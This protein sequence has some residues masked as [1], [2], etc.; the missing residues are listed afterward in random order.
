MSGFFFDVDSNEFGIVSKFLTSAKRLLNEYST[1]CCML[2]T[3]LFR[4]TLVCHPHVDI[5][6]KISFRVSIGI[7]VIN[8]LAI[9]AGTAAILFRRTNVDARD[10]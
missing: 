8:I 6:K 9:I 4:Y 7:V 2:A 10:T 3:A 1:G 5:H